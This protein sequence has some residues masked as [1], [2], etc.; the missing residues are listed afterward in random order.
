M[1]LSLLSISPAPNIAQ[2]ITD[3][4][5][6][7]VVGPLAVAVGVLFLV[8]GW[9]RGALAWTGVI[10]TT[11]F[12]V[13]VVK[14]AV[15]MFLTHAGPNDLKSPSAHTA[16]AASI[17]GGLLA[18]LAYGLSGHRRWTV[19]CALA[20]A[21]AIGATRLALDVHTLPDV[22]VG[23]AIGI[24]SAVALTRLAGPPP[25]LAASGQVVAVV[26]LAG[27]LLHGLQLPAEQILQHI[28]ARLRVSLNRA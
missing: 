19:P 5:D 15:V 8:R 13:L 21:G 24:L 10:A 16:D 17:Y 3:F 9:R 20:A 7:A 18:M 12:A 4:A 1:G 11:M 6:L 23:G 26:V 2:F 14:L 22:F 28:G 25:S 27:L